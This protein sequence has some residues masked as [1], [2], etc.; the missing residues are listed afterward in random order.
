MDYNK[1]EQLVLL[2]KENNE[3]AKEQLVKE[4]TPLIKKLSHK[5]HIFGYEAIDLEN[6]CYQTLFKCVL[7]YNLSSHRFVAYATNALKHT[8]YYLIRKTCDKF[9]KEAIEYVA[10]PEIIDSTKHV[11][12]HGGEESIYSDEEITMIRKAITK[13]SKKD[14]DL[15][16]FVIANKNTL[17]EYAAKNNISYSTAL[18]R[19]KYALNRLKKSYLNIN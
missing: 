16:I 5:N 10:D 11:N 15:L 1:V 18:L 9:K 3:R 14:K 4:F 12:I 19:K 7:Y 2:S 13:L 8:V 17:K 6:E